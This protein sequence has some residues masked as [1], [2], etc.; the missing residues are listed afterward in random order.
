MTIDL[1]LYAQRKG[2]VAK[3]FRGNMDDL[4][5]NIDS[6]NPLIVMVGYGLWLY[7]ANHFMVIVGYDER[8]VIVNSGSD[9]HKFLASDGFLRSWQKTNFWTLLVKGR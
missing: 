8:G 4:K 9:R 6:G 2:M 5:I 1:V 3:Q 7:Q